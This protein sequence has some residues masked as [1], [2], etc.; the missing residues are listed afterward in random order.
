M[1]R[2]R[3]DTAA[4]TC[5]VTDT[6]PLLHLWQAGFAGLLAHLGALHA[7]PAVLHELH[8]HAPGFFADGIPGW[9][10]LARPS[11]DALRRAGH[12]THARVLDKGEAEA[13]AHA[14]EIRADFFLT[15]DTAA[16]TFSES[17]GLHVRG[18]LGVVLHAAARGHLN[19]AASLQILSDLERRSTLWMS[20]KVKATAR[21]AVSRIFDGP[22][23]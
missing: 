2:Q 22:P 13:L 7:T 6:G 20:A 4:M 9:L 15:D 19:R 3:R 18:T 1:G 8:R 21:A 10:A 12:W 17:L 5:V 11:A 23:A 14:L 16:R